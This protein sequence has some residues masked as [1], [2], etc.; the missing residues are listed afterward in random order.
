MINKSLLDIPTISLS[1]LI[2]V[3]A[4]GES[5]VIIRFKNENTLELESRNEH[6]QSWLSQIEL[7]QPCWLIDYS[8]GFDAILIEY[9]ARTIDFYQVFSWLKLIK[10]APKVSNKQRKHKIPVCYQSINH[11]LT[12]DLDTVAEQLKLTPGQVIQLH[13]KNT[14]RI[15][16]LGF[17]PNFAYMGELSKELQIPRRKVPRKMVRAGAVAIA[18]NQTAVYPSNSPG[19]WHIL[20]YTPIAISGI[21]EYKMSVPINDTSNKPASIEVIQF[22]SGDQVEFEP[23]SRQEFLE[24]SKSQS[25]HV[26]D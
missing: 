6:I 14:Y 18:D 9:D 25:F 17:M 13:C 3:Q 26:S 12:T 15:F 2:C 5:S 8:I 24:Q 22:E 23:I 19:G 20:G 11:E 16:A 10:P 4:A 7:E 21:A 1:Q